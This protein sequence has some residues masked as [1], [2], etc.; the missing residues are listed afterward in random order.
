MMKNGY[1]SLHHSFRFT[2]Y[3]LSE[4]CRMYANGQSYKE[5]GQKFNVSALAVEGHILKHY[6]GVIPKENQIKITI[7]MKM[8]E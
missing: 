2:P 7:N 6:L 3:E 5:I 8:E 1:R 4:M